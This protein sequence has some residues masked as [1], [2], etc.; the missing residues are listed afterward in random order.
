MAK[1]TEPGTCVLACLIGFVACVWRQILPLSRCGADS[2]QPAL[3]SL[4][5]SLAVVFVNG[6]TVEFALA[7]FVLA[8]ALLGGSHFRSRLPLALCGR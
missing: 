1:W 2:Y 7:T 6:I 4:R 8:V 3:S 5:H